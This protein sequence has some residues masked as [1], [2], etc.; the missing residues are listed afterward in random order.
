[1]ATYREH[2]RAS[3]GSGLFVCGMSII[4]AATVLN[5]AYD[6]LSSQGL[7]TVAPFLASMYDG[8]GKSGVTS[9]LVAAGLSLILLSFVA[10]RNRWTS[11]PSSDL[12]NMRSVMPY[13]PAAGPSSPEVSPSGTFILKTSRYLSSR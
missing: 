11:R 1:M 12:A 4:I 3:A 6:R 10:Q 2:T 9:V 13:S 7:A 8:S 5:I